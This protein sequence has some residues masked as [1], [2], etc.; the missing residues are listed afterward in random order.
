MNSN[1][2]PLNEQQ[3]FDELLG[4]DRFDDSVCDQHQSD[5]R[6]QVLQAFD[7]PDRKTLRP[8][9]ESQMPTGRKRQRASRSLRGVAIMATCLFGLV[10]IWFSRGNDPP[11]RPIVQHSTVPDVT[12]DSQLVASLAEVNAFRDEVTREEY[13]LA[14]AMCE[15]DHEGRVLS[16][17][18]QL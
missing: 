12:D 8:L 13:F 5:L 18:T 6:S 9:V 11:E 4:D 2:Q 10:A 15:L 16:D 17:S 14:I 3:V 1:E 7:Q